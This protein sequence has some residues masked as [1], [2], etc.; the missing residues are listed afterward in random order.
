[1][2]NQVRLEITGALARLTL[3]RPDKLNALTLS[4]MEAL[5]AACATLERSDQVRAVIL[6]SD[7]PRA[8]CS[9]ADIQ[10]WSQLGAKDMWRSWTRMG[11]RIYDRLATLPMPS[12]AALHGL[13]YGG[14][15]ELAL[16]CDLR[17]A[18][19]DCSFSLPETGVGAIPGWGGTRRLARLVGPARTKNLIFRGM[20][21][22]APTALAWGLIEE[23]VPVAQLGERAK[24]LAEEIAT[25]SPEAVQLCKQLIDAEDGG[26]SAETIAAGLALALPNGREGA[27]AFRARRAPQ[28]LDR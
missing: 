22:D 20:R 2:S 5:D 19:S 4:M 27:E 14:G 16:A 6:D 18:S 8:F 1:M 25:R 26:L 7:N 17:I 11:H 23:H 3:A 10:A 13:A 28:F 9:G 12:I 21:L 15:L 24:A